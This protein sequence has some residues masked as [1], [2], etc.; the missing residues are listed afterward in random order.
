M[1]PGGHFVTSVALSAVAYGGTRSVP[2]AAGCFLG[3]FLIDADHY[4]DYIFV[5]RQWRKPGPAAFLRYYFESRFSRVVLPLHSW[6]V[7]GLLIAV[8][9]L[10][11]APL[12]AGY[13]VGALMHLVFDVMINGEH[14]LR[15][16]VRFYS[17]AFRIHH[18]FAASRLLYICP[19]ADSSLNSQFWSVRPHSGDANSEIRD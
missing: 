18:R 9:I 5:E 8:S 7:L 3:G 17:L 13:V 12:L 19:P 4:F 11:G 2:I 14:V 15:N 16:P 10:S 1:L 6:E